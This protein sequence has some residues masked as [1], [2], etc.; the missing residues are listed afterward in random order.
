MKEESKKWLDY[1][2]ENFRSAKILVDSELYNPALQN[3][4]QAIEKML[5]AL[6]IEFSIKF[7]RTHSINELVAILSRNNVETGV[8]PDECDLLD[9]IYLPSKYPLA[10]VLPDFEPD[11]GICEKCMATAKNLRRRVDEILLK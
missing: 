6:C 3:I 9:S 2:D 8:T 7:Q 1:A 11:A 4:Q 5:K 10:S